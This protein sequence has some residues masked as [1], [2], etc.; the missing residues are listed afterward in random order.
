M[1][2]ETTLYYT[3][4]T[5]SQTLAGAIALLAAFVLYRI[6]LLNSEMDNVIEAT[7]SFLNESFSDTIMELI[8]YEF[9]QMKILK[10]YNGIIDYL[11]KDENENILKNQK[12]SFDSDDKIHVHL[13]EDYSANKKK[14]EELWAFKKK[15]I[16]WLKWTLVFTIIT[17]LYS[18]IILSKAPDICN[19]SRGIILGFGIFFFGV[20]LI[21]YGYLAFT[22]VVDLKSINR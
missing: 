2:D 14:L 9:N 12:I 7:Y 22:S 6:Q 4:S 13:E 5:I 16:G 8:R 17:I 1:I 11:N 18:V 20:C 10:D 19:D 15:L 3:F 21:V